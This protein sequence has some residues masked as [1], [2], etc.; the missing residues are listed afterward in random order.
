MKAKCCV[1]SK[2]VRSSFIRDGGDARCVQVMQVAED[3]WVDAASEDPAVTNHTR[4]IN[5]A[6]GQATNC[7]VFGACVRCLRAAATASHCSATPDAQT[8]VTVMAATAAALT[9]TCINLPLG[10]T[11]SI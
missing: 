9:R 11:R 6:E 1:K 7:A 5:H 4:Y 10:C 3:I 8:A 2:C